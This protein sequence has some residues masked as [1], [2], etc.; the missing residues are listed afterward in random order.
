MI[1]GVASACDMSVAPGIGW[2][3]CGSASH[4]LRLQTGD[5][6]VCSIQSSVAGNVNWGVGLAYCD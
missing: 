2:L 4:E 5:V 6:V 3:I 1:N